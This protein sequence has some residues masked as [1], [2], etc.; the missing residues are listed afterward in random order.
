M[1][2]AGSIYAGIQARI[3]HVC[4]NDVRNTQAVGMLRVGCVKLY[5]DTN[6]HTG[7]MTTYIAMAYI[8]MAYTIMAEPGGA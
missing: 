7:R 5:I 1:L 3:S 6:R 4:C 8:V 2:H